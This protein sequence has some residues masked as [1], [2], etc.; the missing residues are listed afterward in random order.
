VREHVDVQLIYPGG[1][2]KGCGEVHIR[3][4]N[5]DNIVQLE[6][7]GYFR[8]DDITDGFIRLIFAHN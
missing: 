1:V 2:L 4:E 8:I 6:R 7:L 3:G 5:V